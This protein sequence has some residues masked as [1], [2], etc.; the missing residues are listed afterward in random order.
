L[1]LQGNYNQNTHSIWWE[2][3]ALA[4]AQCL[5]GI[6]DQIQ[7]RSSF[8]SDGFLRHLR[9]YSGSTAMG[10]NIPSTNANSFNNGANQFRPPIG[11]NV[12][13]ACV[14][15]AVN[16]LCETKIKP[17]VL[18]DGGSWKLQQKSKD[19]NTFIE[20]L[21]LKLNVHK[22]T[23]MAIKNGSIFGTGV[24]KVCADDGQVVIENIL[25]NEIVVCP[26]DSVYGK[27]RSLYQ[28]R[29]VS[30]Y[31][32]GKAFPDNEIFIKNMQSNTV[33]NGFGNV[34][35]DCVKVIEAWHLP[36]SDPDAT[37]GKHAIVVDGKTLLEEP[38]TK[39][40]FPF[41]FYRHTEL[42][43]GFYGRGMPEELMP[44]QY[45]MNML[46]Q[47][48]S[49]MLKL[50]AVPRIFIDESSQID[51]GQLNNQIGSIIKYRGT[52]PILSTPQA[53]PPEV[54][55]Q[56]DRLYNKAFELQGIPQLQ[57]AGKKPAGVDSGKAL[58]EYAD[59]S[60]TR[61]ITLSQ[62]RE[63]LHVDIALLCFEAC[64]DLSKQ[65][66]VNYKVN[67]FD[68]KE[69]MK[70][71]TYKDVSMKPDFFTVQVWPTNFLSDTPSAKLQDI[72]ELVQAGLIPP[73]SA[74]ALLDFPDI[75]QYTQLTNSGYELARK[76]I[77]SMLEGGPYVPPE[78]TDNLQ[79]TMQLAIQ[80]LAQ[81]KLLEDSEEAV[82]T[83]R[84]YIDDIN[85]L[86]EQLKPPAPMAPPGQPGLPGMPPDGAAP[87]G[88]PPPPPVSD[89]MPIAGGAPPV[90]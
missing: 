9:L 65:Y 62:Q 43:V 29:F 69:G 28:T 88:V 64:A 60:T 54:F 87:M 56:I 44:I 32:L 77:E 58:R 31:D 14:D 47:R 61:F 70:S 19:M 48:A 75:E 74:S 4:L 25:P 24:V 78:E 86:Q 72:Q 51:E 21:F 80:Y 30:K 39:D 22:T 68:K 1:N 46:S 6:V 16:S 18:T 52:A 12:T 57:A 66:G 53:V 49:Q 26:A 17:M 20:G 89:L 50:M 27:P 33:V 2:L 41:A 59:Q 34:V 36:S 45:E 76:T 38:W 85:T 40:H 84:R 37:D 10:L 55:Q 5:F 73:Q 11:Y 79:T 8:I 13:Q 81:A 15:T 67:T 71:L 7:S 63:Q 90:G 83:L 3:E 42:P 23:T 35:T 82:N